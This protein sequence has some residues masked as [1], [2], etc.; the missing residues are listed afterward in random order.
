MT[1]PIL[2]YII[3]M[4]FVMTVNDDYNQ[5]VLYISGKFKIPKASTVEL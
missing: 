5:T 3:A 4:N 2:L 1:I